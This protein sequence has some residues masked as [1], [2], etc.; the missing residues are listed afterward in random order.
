MRHHL[1]RHIQQAHHHELRLWLGR[2]GLKRGLPVLPALLQADRRWRQHHGL[3]FIKR[4]G[5]RRWPLI[6]C[7]Q[8]Q[9]RRCRG[10]QQNG[11]RLAHQP[12]PLPGQQLVQGIVHVPH[13][14][15]GR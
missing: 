1:G 5:Q 8:P 7:R 6:F 14:A 3:A 10:G 11:E 15:I 9:L 4:L 13:R 2:H 12:A